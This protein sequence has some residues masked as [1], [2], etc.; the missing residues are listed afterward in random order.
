[1]IIILT[2]LI[3]LLIII[4]IIITGHNLLAIELLK[5][6]PVTIIPVIVGLL[7][8]EKGNLDTASAL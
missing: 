7:G 3:L 5:L 2:I 4:I 8:C 6:V 1:M